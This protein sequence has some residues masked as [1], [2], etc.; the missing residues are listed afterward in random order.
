MILARCLL[1]CLGLLTACSS[2]TGADDPSPAAPPEEGTAETERDG[3]TTAVFCADARRFI[4]DPSVSD[5]SGLDPRFFA[6]VDRRLGDL[7]II[8]PAEVVA[9]VEALRAGFADSGRILADLDGET[10]DAVLAEAL[11]EVDNESMLGATDN[12][13]RFLT[14]ACGPEAGGAVDGAQVDDIVEAFGVDRALAECINA[15]LGDVANIDSS[16]LTPELLSRPIC[17]TSLLA[18]LAGGAG[19]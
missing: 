11:L 10:D 1:M 17:G 7:A 4:D 3:D 14:L 2:G 12:L 15:E 8:A 19:G 13:R 6:D 5:V 16:R 18:I 9:D